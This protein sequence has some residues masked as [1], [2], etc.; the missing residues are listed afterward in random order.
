[1]IFLIIVYSN[2]QLNMP[3]IPKVDLPT[4]E[5]VEGRREKQGPEQEKAHPQV[6]LVG[7]SVKVV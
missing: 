2:A 1:M 6:I 7:L 4:K 3:Y 5:Q